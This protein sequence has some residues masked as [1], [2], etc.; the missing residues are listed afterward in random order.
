MIS[1]FFDQ[2]DIILN[3]DSTKVKTEIAFLPFVK[4]IVRALENEVTFFKK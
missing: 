1:L 4:N 3:Y 2:H